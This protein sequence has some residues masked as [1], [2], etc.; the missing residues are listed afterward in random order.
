MPPWKGPRAADSKMASGERIAFL[1][2]YRRVRNLLIGKELLRGS[3]RRNR[4]AYEKKESH[5][6]RPSANQWKE[7]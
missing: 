5:F 7:F 1:A 3:L 4:E 6:C 2:S